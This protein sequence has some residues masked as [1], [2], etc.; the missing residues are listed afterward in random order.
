MEQN[1][2]NKLQAEGVAGRKVLR[3]GLHILSIK[4][5]VKERGVSETNNIERNTACSF[6]PFC[7]VKKHK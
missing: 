1:N 3:K 2:M 5:R 4:V 7:K 6:K